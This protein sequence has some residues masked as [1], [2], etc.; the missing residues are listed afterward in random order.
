MFT[1][2]RAALA[3][4][5][6]ASL[7]I[8]TPSARA[9][10]IVQNGASSPVGDVYTYDVV[11]DAGIRQL[12]L[13]GGASPDTIT[14][15]GISPTFQAGLSLPTPSATIPEFT[16]TFSNGNLVLTVVSDITFA[17]NSSTTFSFS[18]TAP[19]ALSLQN[20]SYSLT[21]QDEAQGL[22]TVSTPTLTIPTV[23][24]TASAPEPSTIALAVVGLAGA[25]F[26]RRRKA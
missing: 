8:A 22:I 16:P 25:A 4:I 17:K 24:V 3:L 5:A 26:A 1:A 14:I 12:T 18:I 11:V 6:L 10:I 23:A 15:F 2:K 9:S 19:G 13:Q 7:A 21:Y 20:Q